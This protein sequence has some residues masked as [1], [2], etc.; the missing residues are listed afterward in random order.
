M[1][2]VCFCSCLCFSL[3]L[4]IAS[5]LL[6]LALVLF[7][8][9]SFFLGGD[10]MFFCSC[11]FLSSFCSCM[12]VFLLNNCDILF[13]FPVSLRVSRSSVFLLFFIGVPPLSHYLYIFLPRPPR[14]LE[15]KNHGK[16]TYLIL[17]AFRGSLRKILLQ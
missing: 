15:K 5:S 14:A 9:L 6:N 4:I 10:F 12:C 1:F 8:V 7:F 11:C 17:F 16:N 13:F 3:A 2:L